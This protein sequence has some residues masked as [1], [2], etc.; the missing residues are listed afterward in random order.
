MS[1][2]RTPLVWEVRCADKNLLHAVIAYLPLFSI[3]A[4]NMVFNSNGGKPWVLK[5]FN[6]Y[7]LRNAWRDTASWPL[8]R[9]RS[10]RRYWTISCFNL[11]YT[12]RPLC[13]VMLCAGCPYQC[14]ACTL[15][16]SLVR[17]CSECDE[18]FALSEVDNTCFRTYSA[19]CQINAIST[20]K[21]PNWPLCMLTRMQ[22]KSV[23]SKLEVCNNFTLK[24]VYTTVTDILWFLFCVNT[25][26]HTSQTLSTVSN[27]LRTFD[28][29]EGLTLTLFHRCRR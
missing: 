12:E 7:I 23:I 28:F 15:S 19:I 8:I 6:K 17:T 26:K 14:V 20:L 5:S 13:I 18:A 24:G 1:I 25:A 4:W 21:I 9:N 27:R 29:V 2:F 3:K 22:L 10:H 16:A 11:L